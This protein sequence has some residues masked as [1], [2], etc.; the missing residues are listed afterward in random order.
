MDDK[1]LLWV[2]AISLAAGAVVIGG[3]FWLSVTLIGWEH[4]KY[5]IVAW[6]VLTL[7]RY[8]PV[9]ISK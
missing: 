2:I 6:M 3:A 9:S 7:S 8:T 1:D 5:A 4:T